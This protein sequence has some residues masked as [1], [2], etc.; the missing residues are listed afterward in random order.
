M[1]RESFEWSL[2][3][4]ESMIRGYHEYKTVW[5]NPDLAEELCCMRAIG[6][7]RDLAA[8]TIQKQISGEIVITGHI[9]KSLEYYRKVAVTPCS[10][11]RLPTSYLWVFVKIKYGFRFRDSMIGTTLASSIGSLY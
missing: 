4:A 9:P 7:P 8:V 5:E 3:F 6:N 11:A 10:S 2:P 1:N